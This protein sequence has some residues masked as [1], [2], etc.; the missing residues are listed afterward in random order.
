MAERK[1]ARLKGLTVGVCTSGSR[2]KLALLAGGGFSSASRKCLNQEKELFPMLDRLLA[3]HKAG[4]GDISVLCVVNGPGRFTGLRVGLTFASALKTL[5]GIEVRSVT[6]FDVLAAQAASSRA[7]M[8]WAAGRKAPVLAAVV[9]AFKD[10]YFCQAFSAGVRAG[11]GFAGSPLGAPRWLKEGEVRDYL[12]S[13][14]DGAYAAADSEERPDIY[15]LLPPGAARAP[16]GVS[17]VLPE[18]IIKAGLAL[19]KKDL[20]P[21]Y[22]KP[23]KYEIGA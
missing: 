18:F 23:A 6:L 1:R 7:F 4:L 8:A 17:R 22:L 21:L 5:A 20:S 19:G 3:P 13:F 14:G 11:R 2:L 9:H 16:A 15:S 10:E 12:G